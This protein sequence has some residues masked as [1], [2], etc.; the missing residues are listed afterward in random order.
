M[1]PSQGHLK[2]P[3]TPS[4]RTPAVGI[5]TLGICLSFLLLLWLASTVSFGKAIPL[6]TVLAPTFMYTADA[7][8]EELLFRPQWG[9]LDGIYIRLECRSLVALTQGVLF[10]TVPVQSLVLSSC[11][12][13]PWG[14]VVS[15]K[16]C[17]SAF[18]HP[19]TRPP[20]TVAV[21]RTFPVIPYC[22]FWRDRAEVTLLS[23]CVLGGVCSLWI[24]S[25]FKFFPPFLLE[26]LFLISIRLTRVKFFW[27]FSQ[28]LVLVTSHS[29]S[30]QDGE[31]N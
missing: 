30:G 22:A 3:I 4:Q 24:S 28:G 23:V 13:A 31:K 17:N 18:C 10:G 7:G 16:L 2:W 26:D 9:C 25:R 8:S 5:H 11:S 27:R 21:T 6:R 29:L 12:L 1:D 14:C 20:N 15:S 19:V